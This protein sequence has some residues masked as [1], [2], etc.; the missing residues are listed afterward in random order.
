MAFELFKKEVKQEDS[1]IT[2]FSN[3]I[4]D[5]SRRLMLVESRIKAI[6]DKQNEISKTLF[7]RTN[8][9]EKQL[10]A[11]TEQIKSNRLKA[12]ILEQKQSYLEKYL[13]IL[14]PKVDLMVLRAKVNL[15]NP[16]Y[17]MSKEEVKTMID[18]KFAE[19]AQ[20]KMTDLKNAKEQEKYK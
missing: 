12:D 17:L 4:S 13:H 7:E 2:L 6:S 3:Q 1:N 9:L 10:A 5:I 20:K 19:S 18:E 8:S 15:L 16:L 11:I 14:A